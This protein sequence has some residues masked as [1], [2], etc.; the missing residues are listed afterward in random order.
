MP[1]SVVKLQFYNLTGKIAVDR[2]WKVILSKKCFYTS[3]DGNSIADK[4]A[5]VA[6]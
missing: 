1:N 4:W 3:F 6:I 5:Y 2:R